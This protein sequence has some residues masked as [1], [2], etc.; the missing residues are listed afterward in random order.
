MSVK[1]NIVRGK[2]DYWGGG[3]F[4]LMVTVFISVFFLE[5]NTYP[6]RLA[7]LIVFL[8]AVV[9]GIRHYFIKNYIEIGYLHFFKDKLRI[10]EFDNENL[11]CIKDI[12]YVKYSINDVGFRTKYGNGS[13][14]YIEI[15]TRLGK[16]KFRCYLK[17]LY[18][19]KMLKR[20][21]DLWKKKGVSVKTL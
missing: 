10:V 6:F 21:L 20:H 5:I 11:L 2:K 13:S 3:M 15:R 4:A 14:N 1:V 17:N 12:V 8:L 7:F 9:W 16:K 19:Q 18:Q